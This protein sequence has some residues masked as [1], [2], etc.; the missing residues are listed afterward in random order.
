MEATLV[1]RLGSEQ[2]RRTVL[3]ETSL[4]ALVGARA[5]ERFAF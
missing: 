5:P 4:K 1:E 3:F 2:W